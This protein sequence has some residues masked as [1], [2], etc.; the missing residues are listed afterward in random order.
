MRQQRRPRLQAIAMLPRRWLDWAEESL[1]NEFCCCGVAAGAYRFDRRGP[2]G[3]PCQRRH[4]R[5]TM[6]KIGKAK[7]EASRAGETPTGAA[8]LEDMFDA[9]CEGAEEMEEMLYSMD[10]VRVWW[11]YSRETP[12]PIVYGVDS[13]RRELT[14]D[15]LLRDESGSHVWV[16]G[17]GR[18]VTCD[19]YRQVELHPAAAVTWA[20]LRFKASD[21]KARADTLELKEVAYVPSVA[22]E[23]D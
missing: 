9:Y 14:E 10:G 20:G 2:V 23:E 17:A 3:D 6:D 8:G 12:V 21:V 16:N 22:A 5:G 15:R 19:G 4:N 11:D 18:V 1:G 13:S 7:K